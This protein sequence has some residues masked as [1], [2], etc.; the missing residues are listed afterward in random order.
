VGH[1]L[2]SAEYAETQRNFFDVLWG[3]SKEPEVDESGHP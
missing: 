3:V 2:E 1:H